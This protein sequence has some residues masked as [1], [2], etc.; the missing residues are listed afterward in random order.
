MP[1]CRTHIKA[2]VAII[3]AVLLCISSTVAV[4][5]ADG[6]IATD[7]ENYKEE[8]NARISSI[9]IPSVLT[10]LFSGDI[11]FD[12]DGEIFVLKLDGLKIVKVVPTTSSP[13]FEV[14]M[15]REFLNKL[16]IAEDT[17]KLLTYGIRTGEVD[18]TPHGTA[19][20]VKLKASE[21]VIAEVAEAPILTNYLVIYS[22]RGLIEKYGG[23]DAS[24]LI[25][26]LTFY[27]E[28]TSAYLVNIDP[29]LV[30]IEKYKS[31]HLLDKCEK[32][33]RAIECA[34]IE[35]GGDMIR[36]ILLVGDDGVIPFYRVPDLVNVSDW[37]EASYAAGGLKSS[38]VYFTDDNYADLND[39]GFVDVAIGRVIGGDIEQLKSM[40]SNSP[41]LESAALAAGGYP[42]EDAAIS[43]SLASKAVGFEVTE[44]LEAP[45]LTQFT[46]QMH[47]KSLIF[48]S[49]HADHIGYHD[50]MGNY[51]LSPQNLKDL[52]LQ[53]KE[54]AVVSMGCHSGFVLEDMSASDSVVLAWIGSGAK[55]IASPSGYAFGDT[56]QYLVLTEEVVA[57]FTDY[58]L[59]GQSFGYAMM[60]AKKNYYEKWPKSLETAYSRPVIEKSAKEVILF[61]DPT[62]TM[63]PPFQYKEQKMGDAALDAIQKA[64]Y[65]ISEANIQLELAYRAGA[66]VSTVSFLIGSASSDLYAAGN[67]YDN[68]NF[69]V[70]FAYASNAFK[71]AEAAK[72]L[73]QQLR[74]EVE[75]RKNLE[76]ALIIVP[77]VLLIVPFLYY[78]KL[79]RKEKKQRRKEKK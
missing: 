76:R 26:F 78:L 66:D 72:V 75:R 2:Y 11:R 19:N 48:Y 68:E 33:D 32:F 41:I 65:S 15:S 52:D 42:F 16:L 24:A 67:A 50:G 25:G 38:S 51:F 47:D 18:V 77:I 17:V 36:Y 55:C 9:A 12:V 3:L 14:K 30:R 4:Q 5:A 79:R 40:L 63:L 44:I 10:D 46:N 56:T 54:V 13:L 39:D 1:T 35:T 53:D 37:N 57:D 34:V 61:G 70:S 43:A 8:Y 6:S 69:P 71:K 21:L 45:Q 29:Y 58:F 22:N 60:N 28:E 59:A 49:Y 62:K 23:N 74:E 20:T 31:G 73:A 7:I 27:S 64:T